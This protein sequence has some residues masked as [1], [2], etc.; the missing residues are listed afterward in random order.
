MN[1][2]YREERDESRRINGFI[3][4]EVCVDEL[5]SVL[6]TFEEMEKSKARNQLILHTAQA[7]RSVFIVADA[8]RIVLVF[9][10]H[11]SMR[12]SKS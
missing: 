10:N 2:T 1:C 3:L 6:E 5:P 7:G 9:D 11:W 12:R 4:V 8:R